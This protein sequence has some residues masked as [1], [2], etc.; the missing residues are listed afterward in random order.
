LVGALFHAALM[1]HEQG[2]RGRVLAVLMQTGNSWQQRMDAPTPLEFADEDFVKKHLII[3]FA[4]EY[5]S[6]VPNNAE[7]AAR[8]SPRGGSLAIM[9]TGA[10]LA[11]WRRNVLPELNNMATSHMLRT[12]HINPDDIHIMGQY[13]VVPFTSRT[14]TTP[15]VLGAVPITDSGYA[16]F[17][18]IRF[19]KRV[20]DT[21]G[22]RPFDAGRFLDRGLPPTAIFEFIVEEVQIR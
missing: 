15:N 18:K 17:L 9:A 5:L 11:E 7:L 13:Y 10:V 16:M 4:S 19:N 12:I 8:A 21:M 20:R 2:Q 22:G 6:V 3:K 1:I 14:W